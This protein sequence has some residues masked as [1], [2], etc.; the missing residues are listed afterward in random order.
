L[1]SRHPAEIRARVASLQ[2]QRE[3][4]QDDVQGYL[5][6]IENTMAATNVAKRSMEAILLVAGRL[7]KTP[8]IRIGFY[9]CSRGAQVRSRQELKPHSFS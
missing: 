4:H 1:F 9:I 3:F 6:V 5:V 7:W 2:L 8:T